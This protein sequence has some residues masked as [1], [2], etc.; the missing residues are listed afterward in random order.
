V[1]QNVEVTK[2]VIITA[3]P[4]PT[5]VPL[6]PVE[7]TYYYPGAAQADLPAVQ[8]AMNQILQ[9]KINAK[10]KLVQLDWGAYDQKMTLMFQS[11]EPCDIVFT[12][13]GS[14]ITSNW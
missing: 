1:T 6:E 3:T 10:I 8:Y 2:E 14:T 11:Q 5:E 7:I 4:V 9:Q 13:P 12:L